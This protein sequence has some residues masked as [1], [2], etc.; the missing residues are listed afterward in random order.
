[1]ILLLLGN[2][3]NMRPHHRHDRASIHQPFSLIPYP[4]DVDRQWEPATNKWQEELSS[5]ILKDGWMEQRIMWRKI[6][7][8]S[9]IARCWGDSTMTHTQ[10]HAQH[11]SI[12]LLLTD[13]RLSSSSSS[14]ASE[15]ENLLLPF[16]F[17]FWARHHCQSQRSPLQIPHWEWAIRHFRP[18]RLTPLIQRVRP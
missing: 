18:L 14:A 17:E 5:S 2:R 3:S 6:F 1:M 8:F 16:C 4:S 12:V 13:D 10:P 9:K 7:F 15:W 11:N